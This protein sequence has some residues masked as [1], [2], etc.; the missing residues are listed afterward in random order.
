VVAHY[1]DQESSLEKTMAAQGQYRWGSLWLDEKD[2]AKIQAEEKAVK[3]KMDSLKKDFD[4]AQ[5]DLLRITRTI[6]DDK[7]IQQ[8]IASSTIQ[9]DAATGRAYQLPLPQRYYDLDRDIKSLQTEQVIKQRQLMDMQTLMNQQEKNLPTPKYVGI[10]RAFD[11]EAMPGGGTPTA[12][13]AGSNV[14]QVA[15]PPTTAP[16][17][18]TPAVPVIPLPATTRQA[19]GGVDFSVPVPNAPSK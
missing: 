14:S 10:Q 12:V 1:Q 5:A 9:L 2:F 16:A 6:Q 11:V 19:N 18:A 17:A 8:A 3:E 13:A 15:A 7:Q 4:A